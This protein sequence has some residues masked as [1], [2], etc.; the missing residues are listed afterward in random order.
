[1][2][3]TRRNIVTG[4]EGCGKSSTLFQYLETIA[5]PEAPILYAV[6]NY[7]LMTEQVLNWSNRF[8]IPFDHF[9]I[10][11]F[12]KTYEPA[13]DAYT[14]PDMPY[15]LGKNARFIFTSQAL[16]QRGNHKQFVDAI[17]N[18]VKFAHVVV[19]EFDFV[20]GIIPSLD[21]ELGN[22]RADDIKTITVEKKLNWIESN[23]SF[24]DRV[25]L[26]LAL[27]NHKSEFIFADWIES[28][29]CP[30]TFLSSEKLVALLFSTVGFNV[31]ELGADRFDHEV[32]VFSSEHITGKFFDVMN[33]N[34][35]WNTL[36]YDLIISDCINSHFENN[37]EALKVSAISH[38]GIRGSNAHRGKK[39]L[40]VL[41]HIPKQN[42]V[43]IK[44]A[45]NFLGCRISYNDVSSMFYRDRLCQAVGRVIGYRASNDMACTDIVIHRDIYTAI[46]QAMFPYRF[47]DWD[48]DF[49][50]KE[51]TFKAVS[52]KKKAAKEYAK[53]AMDYSYLNA[54]FCSDRN[55]AFPVA[56][57]KAF[58]VA[59]HIKAVPATK[60]AKLF[61]GVITN[62]SINKKPVRIIK[63]VG[64]KK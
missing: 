26:M 3:L 43:L 4:L 54:Y 5:T 30:L 36:D 16:V 34:V 2:E 20:S 39:I 14:N 42:I 31:I 49:P 62:T 44:D 58:M 25:N 61:G 8:N 12:G 46:D 11:G 40:T 59:Q 37:K 45:L 32:R 1:M 55:A 7:K 28:C 22:M 63:G 21:Y 64:L 35:T 56:D 60:V 10:C 47:T 18:Y 51:A 13:L 17:G 41:S 24:K 33:K 52:Q 53:L 57:L 19:D 6:K 9:N 23:Y 29:A 50:A 15:M 38:M 48:F 27:K